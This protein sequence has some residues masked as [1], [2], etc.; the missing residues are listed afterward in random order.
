MRPIKSAFKA[1]WKELQLLLVVFLFALVVGVP[2]FAV[3]FVMDKFAPDWLAAIFWLG[4]AIWMF[5]GDA[6]ANGYKAYRA[7]KR[8]LADH[9]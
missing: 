2:V 1:A 6:I 9:E 4:L 7:A 5:F 3:I 8:E